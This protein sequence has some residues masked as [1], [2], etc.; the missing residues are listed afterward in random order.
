LAIAENTLTL[1]LEHREAKLS[2]LRTTIFT[3]FKL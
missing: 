3:G 1:H 2:C